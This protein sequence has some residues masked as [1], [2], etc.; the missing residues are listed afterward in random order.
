MYYE[1]QMIKIYGSPLSSAHR[2][3]W[4]MEEM[5]VPYERQPLDMKKKEHKSESFLKLNP[6]GKIPCIVDGDLV[7][8]ESAAINHYLA[9]K[10][11]PQL[12]GK[13]PEMQG[14]V[15]QWTLWGMLEMQKPLIDILIQVMFVPEEKKNPS[16]IEEAK[17]KI[18]PLNG[19]LNNHL[20]NR[21]F[22]VGDDFTL[23]D[24]NIASIVGI[25]KI[26]GQSL[27]AYPHIEKWLAAM[28]DRPAHKKV[29]AMGMVP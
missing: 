2:C 16:V 13:G 14:M 28:V 10:Y 5:K 29:E 19:I 17:K 11:S 1:G 4:A 26:T 12:L 18:E 9:L 20:R 3:Y 7:L 15:W 25:N 22:I 23:A 8:W 27:S 24:L 6:N 21:K